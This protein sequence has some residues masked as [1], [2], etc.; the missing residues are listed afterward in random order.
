MKEISVYT[1]KTP[2]STPK[3]YSPS[4]QKRAGSTDMAQVLQLPH[5][6]GV[7]VARQ[8]CTPRAFLRFAQGTAHY[9]KKYSGRQDAARYADCQKTIVF[10]RTQ[11][12][13]CQGSWRRR[14]LRGS[15]RSEFAVNLI[16]SET[17]S[18]SLPQ[19]RYRSA[20]PSSEGAIPKTDFFDTLYSGRQDAARYGKDGF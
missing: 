10:G 5:R 17:F 6:R 20:A 4:S 13:P 1:Q 18:A 7:Y 9:G 16:I 2:P 14:R 11:G 19:L 15:K 3:S 8:G 12:S